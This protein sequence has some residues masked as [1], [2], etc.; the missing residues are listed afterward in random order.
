MNALS[1]SRRA[2][3]GAHLLTSYIQGKSIGLIAFNW[4]CCSMALLDLPVSLYSSM[5]QFNAQFQVK[6]AAPACLASKVRWTL[7]GSSSV[8]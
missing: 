2:S 8:L 1:K 5:R 3:C 4:R 7:L 6:R